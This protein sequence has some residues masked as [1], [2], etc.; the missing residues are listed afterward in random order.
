MSRSRSRLVWFRFD[1]HGK[2][3]RVVLVPRLVSDV[4]GHELLG[5]TTYRRSLI[6]IAAWQPWDDLCETVLHEMM[7][8]A[9]WTGQIV[10]GDV[11]AEERFI[12]RAEG[13][14]W[15]IVAQFGFRLPSFPNG[16]DSLRAQAIEAKGAA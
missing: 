9:G 11:M 14:L 3:W 6:E 2:R 13:P 10:P 5:L 1:A 8:A 12:A 16:F 15:H 7:H 4:D